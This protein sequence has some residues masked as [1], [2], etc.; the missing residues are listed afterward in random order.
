MALRASGHSGDR[1]SQQNGGT[2]CN[3]SART[4]RPRHSAGIRQKMCHVQWGRTGPWT[5]AT[6]RALGASLPRSEHQGLAGR[7]QLGR[8]RP[9]HPSFH[10]LERATLTPA[11]LPGPD[12]ALSGHLHSAKAGG[13]ASSGRCAVTGR[14]GPGASDAPG[15]PAPRCPGTAGRSEARAP[16]P[17]LPSRGSPATPRP[18]EGTRPHGGGAQGLS[19]PARPLPGLTWGGRRGDAGPGPRRGA[20]CRAASRSTT[21]G[22]R[23]LVTSSSTRRSCSGPSGARRRTPPPSAS[24]AAMAAGAGTRTPVS[25]RRTAARDVRHLGAGRPTRAPQAKTPQR[26]PRG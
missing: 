18:A 4:R 7:A 10:Q 9:V 22:G 17:A 20:A 11:E 14:T 26:A 6:P 25:V 2:S 12:A 8:G 13:A 1:A 16:T 15:P 19:V 23:A 3:M 5:A 24:G 21:G